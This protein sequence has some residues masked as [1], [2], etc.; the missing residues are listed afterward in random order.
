MPKV[1]NTYNTERNAV[2]YVI[3]ILQKWNWVVEEMNQDFGEDLYV[4]IPID[5]EIGTYNAFKVQIKGTKSPKYNQHNQLTYSFKTEWL[6]HWANHENPIFLC[7]VDLTQKDGICYWQN[8]NEELEDKLQKLNEQNT[9]SINFSYRN[10]LSSPYSK[11]KI[12]TFVFWFYKDGYDVT[13]KKGK[14]IRS[15][16]EKNIKYILEEIPEFLYIETSDTK[17]ILWNEIIEE[18]ETLL[19]WLRKHTEEEWPIDWQ[20]AR[21]NLYFLVGNPSKSLEIFSQIEIDNL[22]QENLFAVKW[23]YALTSFQIGDFEEANRKM[24]LLIEEYPDKSI[25]YSHLGILHRRIKNYQKAISYHKK[26]IEINESEL[27]SYASLGGCYRDI[28]KLNEAENILERG[29]SIDPNH[30]AVLIA[31]AALKKSM[32][33]YQDAIFL[34]ERLLLKQSLNS[35]EGIVTQIGYAAALRKIGNFEKSK[36]IY[37]QVLTFEPNNEYA[38]GGFGWLLIDMKDFIYAKK[39]LGRGLSINPKSPV[40]L[41][42]LKRVTQLL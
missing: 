15:I 14:K 38:L 3:S 41:N 16:V 24:E 19:Q 9:Y 36:R 13:S 35:V 20:I 17:I 1:N 31:T 11:H 40:L 30:S 6:K 23:M 29:L 27:D 39:I 37:E 42:G 12:S 18:F 7:V 8:I 28:R 33:K 34:Y 5:E 10:I 26:A 21:G 22:N 4:K 25:I 2:N 32:Q